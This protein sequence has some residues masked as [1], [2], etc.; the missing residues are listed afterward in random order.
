[1]QQINK[2]NVSYGILIAAIASSMWGVS[3]TVLQFVSQGEN[4]PASWFLSVR[5][6]GTGLILL[7]IS[8]WRYGRQTWSVFNNTRTLLWLIAY[9]FLG[10]G[11]NLLTFYHA[12]QTGNAATATI[13]QY[14]SP[15]FI[16]LGSLL[17]KHQTPLK[18][19]MVAFSLSIVGVFL[20]ITHGQF[21]SLAISSISLLWG[22][23]SGVTAAFYIVLP[24]PVAQ[25]GV[26]PITILGW[27]ALFAS[28]GF[29]SVHPFWIEAPALTTPLVLSVGTMILIGTVIPFSLLIYSS[30]FAPSDV[31]GIMD[32][33][34]PVMTMILSVIFFRT[35]ISLLEIIG[36]LLVIFAIYWLQRGRRQTELA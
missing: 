27:G 5:T 25:Q 2:K 34:Q 32:A 33:I 20:T 9:A 24:K 15:F 12:V 6:L 36:C 3:G 21:S 18:S 29:N 23:G 31:I 4:L 10:L 35:S 28:L 30:H 1:M 19:D 7:A 8:F 16:V 22:L 14:L 13:L 17:F 26:P 11:A